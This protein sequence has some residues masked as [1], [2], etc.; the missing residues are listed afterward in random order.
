M[1]YIAQNFDAARTIE[2]VKGD[3][4]S[5]FCCCCEVSMDHKAIHVANNQQRRIL[6]SFAI[7]QELIVSCV[8]IL[9]FALILPSKETPLPHIS[10]TLAA[11]M[12]CC[13]FFESEAFACRV[14]FCGCRMIEHATEIE[15]MLLRGGTLS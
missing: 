2:I 5:L 10:P 3:L 12:F 1:K 14:C 6:K 9:M 15:K 8:K 11:A 7:Q 4:V 13:A